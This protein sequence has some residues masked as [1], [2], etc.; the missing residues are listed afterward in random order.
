MALAQRRSCKRCSGAT[1]RLPRRS[2]ARA[3]RGW[4]ADVRQEF[5]ELVGLVHALA[6]IREV[7]PRS[8]DAVLAVGELVS[9]RIVAAALADHRV[10]SVWVDARTVLVTDA[11]HMGAVPDSSRPA[12][13]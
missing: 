7:S 12:S 11:E 9:S 4:V 8:H 3:A 5:D 6:V 10:P 2:P 1:S 13:G